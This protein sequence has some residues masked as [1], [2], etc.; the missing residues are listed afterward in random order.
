MNTAGEAL[1]LMQEEETM[2]ILRWIM[3]PHR[4]RRAGMRRFVFMILMILV[5]AQIGAQRS[6]QYHR[7]TSRP[8]PSAAASYQS[9]QECEADT[10]KKCG[11]VMCDYVPPGKTYEEVC[12]NVAKGWQPM[13]NAPQAQ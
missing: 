7:A 4:R 2:S 13:P 11:F 6:R 9:Q 3:P 10:G 5:G 8:M 1:P 12:G